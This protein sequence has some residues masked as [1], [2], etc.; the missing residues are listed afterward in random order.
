M[1]HFQEVDINAQRLVVEALGQRN[2]QAGRHVLCHSAS[3]ICSKN[4]ILVTTHDR[5]EEL[6]THRQVEVTSV[7]PNVSHIRRFCREFKEDFRLEIVLACHSS[8]DPADVI[9]EILGKFSNDFFSLKR[10]EYLV[11]L[12]LGTYWKKSSSIAY[13]ISISNAKQ[14]DLHLFWKYQVNNQ[15]EALLPRAILETPEI[16]EVFNDQRGPLACKTLQRN[17]C[18]EVSNAGNAVSITFKTP[19]R[20]AKRHAEAVDQLIQQCRELVD[21]YPACVIQYKNRDFYEREGYMEQTVL[22]L[23][24]LDD[25]QMEDLVQHLTSCKVDFY[26]PAAK[27]VV[28][29]IH[30]VD[31][32]ALVRLFHYAEIPIPTTMSQGAFSVMTAGHR[33]QGINTPAGWLHKF[34]IRVGRMSALNLH[35]VQI[36]MNNIHDVITDE[37]TYEV[38]VDKIAKDLQAVS[39]QNVT[40]YDSQRQVEQYLQFQI[41]YC[42]IGS[43]PK[44]YSIGDQ[45][46]LVE[47]ALPF[48]SQMHNRRRPPKEETMHEH[49]KKA[50]NLSPEKKKDR[51]NHLAHSENNLASLQRA[52]SLIEMAFIS[53]KQKYIGT[54]ERSLFPLLFVNG[55]ADVQ[56][57][58]N[59]YVNT[60]KVDCHLREVIGTSIDNYNSAIGPNLSHSKEHSV[61]YGLKVFGTCQQPLKV[62]YVMPNRNGFIV[63]GTELLVCHAFTDCLLFLYL[64]KGV[65]PETCCT[66]RSNFQI[67]LQIPICNNSDKVSSPAVTSTPLGVNPTQVVN[68]P[69]TPDASQGEKFAPTIEKQGL[70][71]PDP[72]MTSFKS[73]LGEHGHLPA[74]RSSDDAADVQST[75]EWTQ[76]P[77]GLVDREKKDDDPIE[78]FSGS[79]LS[80]HQQQTSDGN[81]QAAPDNTKD[82]SQ[83]PLAPIVEDD[84]EIQI[85]SALSAVS[86][87][88]QKGPKKNTDKI[89][90]LKG[91]KFARQHPY[92]RIKDRHVNR[93][94]KVLSQVSNGSTIDHLLLLGGHQC[95]IKNTPSQCTSGDRRS[96]S[97]DWNGAGV[98][99]RA[100]KLV[101]SKSCPPTRFSFSP[102]KEVLKVATKGDG[103]DKT[104]IR[105]VDGKEAFGNPAS[106]TIRGKKPLI[107]RAG[108]T[109]RI[110]SF[111]AKPVEV[112]VPMEIED[113]LQNE[114]NHTQ[115]NIINVEDE[116]QQRKIRDLAKATAKVQD[117]STKWLA[118]LDVDTRNKVE[119]TA[120]QILLSMHTTFC[121][122][123][124]AMRLLTKAPW[125]EN[126]VSIDVRQAALV[127][128][129]KGWYLYTNASGSFPFSPAELAIAAG[130]YE[131]IIEPAAQDDVTH[132]LK[133]IIDHL[134]QECDTFFTKAKAHCPTCGASTTG[135]IHILSTSI[136]WIEQRW[137]S[138][139]EIV[140]NAEPLLGRAEGSWHALQC[141]R[142]ET[143]FTIDKLGRWI[144]LE[145]RPVDRLSNTEQNSDFFPPISSARSILTDVS[146]QEES[147]EITGFVCSDV[148][149][150][151]NAHYWLAEARNGQIQ[152]IYDSLKGSQQLTAEVWKKLRVTG[153]L[154]CKTTVTAPKMSSCLLD[155]AAGKI[156]PTMRLTRPIK[157][158]CRQ[159]VITLR[160]FLKQSGDKSTGKRRAPN[161]A[162]LN[163]NRFSKKPTCARASKAKK[164]RRAVNRK[165]NSATSRIPP[166]IENIRSSSVEKDGERKSPIGDPSVESVLN[167]D[168]GLKSGPTEPCAERSK[169]GFDTQL[170]SDS[171]IIDQTLKCTESHGALKSDQHQEISEDD[172]VSCKKRDAREE[173]NCQ[174]EAPLPPELPKIRKTAAVSLVVN[175]QFDVAAGCS[176]YHSNVQEERS[177]RTAGCSA[178]PT[179]FPDLVEKSSEEVKENCE[180]EPQPQGR[181]G[182]IS[183]FDG[184]SS[185]VPLLKKKVGY[186]PVVAILAE[187]DNRIRSLVCAEFGYRSDE[188]W[189]YVIDGSAVLYLRDVHSLVANGCRILQMTLKMFPD[190]KWIVVGGSPCQD[191]TLA[192]TMKGV[193]GLTGMSSRLFFILL[194]VIYTVQIE[195]GPAAVRFLVE[196]AGS[197]QKMH[198]EAFCK[199]LSLPLMHDRDYIWDPAQYGYLVTRCRN[200]FRNYSDKEPVGSPPILF[201][202]KIGPLIDSSGRS[203]P[204]APLLRA[205]T[206]LPYGIVC[207]SWTLYQPHALVWD[208][209]Y[210]GT[211]HDFGRQAGK[212]TN[213]IP[214]FQWERIIPPPFLQPWLAFLNHLLAKKGSGKD[215]DA[216]IGRLLPLFSCK[217]YHIPCRVLTE[218]EVTILSGLEGHWTRI[219][220]DDA[221][222]MPEDLIRSMCGNSF[223]PGLIGSA[224]GSNETLKQ[225]IKQSF[226]GKQPYVA[227]REIA[228]NVF[229]DLVNQV[230]TQIDNTRGRHTSAH[231]VSVDPTLPVFEISKPIPEDFQQPIIHPVSLGR[232][233]V[234]ELTKSDQR[235]QFCVE[236]A[237]QSLE[238]D[239]CRALKIAGQE[240]LFEAMRAPVTVGFWFESLIEALWG[241]HPNCFTRLGTSAQAP[242]LMLLSKVQKAL[243]NYEQCRSGAAVIAVLLSIT[244]LKSKSF[245]PVGF[246]TI[247]GHLRA[248]FVAYVGDSKPRLTFLI[249]CLNLNQPEVFVVSA[250]AYNQELKLKKAPHI[251]NQYWPTTDPRMIPNFCIECRDG[252][253]T[254]NVW[255][256]H[257]K[258]TSC[259]T[260]I[261]QKMGQIN[262]CPWHPNADEPPNDLALRACH[263]WCHKDP[264]TSIV[265]VTG[266][267]KLHSNSFTISIFHIASGDSVAPLCGE[268]CRLHAPVDFL[269][270]TL[271]ESFI[272]PEDLAHIAAPFRNDGFPN[273]LYRHFFLQ[274]G[275]PTQSI[276]QWL[277]GWSPA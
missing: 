199:L 113:E 200:F 95:S 75:A 166:D 205:R 51:S 11:E 262:F 161:K 131:G 160:N 120:V 48:A 27:V 234:V 156:P 72:A 226:E 17:G 65:R 176:A 118:N 271:S 77:P 220:E 63:S 229:T 261:L 257:C 210:W 86:L 189:C 9:I 45:S 12:P 231:K 258:Q 137:T 168:E 26:I 62:G 105:K 272:S 128:I 106:K 132:G 31:C 221:K 30:G 191:L 13:V 33:N 2:F 109:N 149:E 192:G 82:S 238:P 52:N 242:C 269:V 253:W 80:Y 207:S 142:P 112:P 56:D 241:M 85:S 165:V 147:I 182:V 185:V 240:E 111:F 183:L 35:P 244:E 153:L 246:I 140:F 173:E 78:S 79:L 237:A 178:Y 92:H 71:A 187:N 170:I 202:D 101:H 212:L 96:K 55:L 265:T 184:V 249:K 163:T 209:G 139:K 239:V 57:C 61:L 186:A 127:A 152:G 252:Q 23:R 103:I 3:D 225:W 155:E 125:T 116:E 267:T 260:C 93:E 213:K 18:R 1:A 119:S 236:A 90:N 193:L 115:N 19:F 46:I 143:T 167:N 232:C 64:P 216:E 218:K 21:E 201:N 136:T 273:D 89:D 40:C 104:A 14:D 180:A 169:Q 99:K 195:V 148:S 25:M 50:A 54:F 254:T 91:D 204:F 245:W 276:E 224:L 4:G 126:M 87:S 263:F 157:V 215:I 81:R 22:Y 58:L 60:L 97:A 190:C 219:S 259:H 255:G 88:N 208:Y 24:H 117:A 10:V 37:L 198:L 121:Y 206:T 110:S 47:H 98:T 36:N 107:R 162:I 268:F 43:Y 175:P 76:P 130:L 69:F 39:F 73:Q 264:A 102:R 194:C 274:V 84:D 67:L 179:N 250:T 164:P 59:T 145:F 256:Y 68:T 34:S 270:S 223:H 177:S 74:V 222:H 146:L 16:S 49:W 266:Y 42:N 66:P 251:F 277:Q 5:L 154:L 243:C 7:F 15:K 174:S 94:H 181:Y 133:V 230:R 196:N 134:P 158:Q 29:D 248:P 53:S 247:F 32:A 235:K 211:R 100:K 197:M 171:G 44:T 227:N 114:P 203:I 172:L 217:N 28:L 6:L 144:Y 188:E 83:F 41:P 129:S 108:Q 20:N 122:Y 150:W 233:N 138:L 8:S 214:N 124:V 38:V 123:V 70:V 135:L 159:K 228:Y 141:Q 275:G 151:P